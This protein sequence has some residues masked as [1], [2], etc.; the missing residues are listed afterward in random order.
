MFDVRWKEQTWQRH[1]KKTV[2]SCTEK[3]HAKTLCLM[4]W[5][6]ILADTFDI[7]ESIVSNFVF[8]AFHFLM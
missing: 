7:Q 5:V 1:Q 2:S 3:D 4:S 6:D 8:F